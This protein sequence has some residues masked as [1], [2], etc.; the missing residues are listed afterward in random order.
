MRDRRSNFDITDSVQL[1]HAD[2]THRA[3]H[4]IF[5][6][7][8]KQYN[9]SALA[10][11]FD[12][13]ERLFEGDY[14][15]YLPCDT[16]YHDKQHTLD[17][18]LALARL[19]GGHERS[20]AKDKRIGAQRAVIAIITSLFHDSGYIRQEN[21]HNHFN[22]AEY[23]QTHVSRSAD[24]LKHYLYKIKLGEYAQLSARLV[25][26]SGYEIPLDTIQ[27]PDE[28]WRMSGY[29]LGTADVISQMADRC[30]LEKC[31]DRLYP[32]FVL[33]GLVVEIDSQGKEK[34]LYHSGEDLL[35]KTPDFFANDI[36]NR[37]NKVL[38]QTYLYEKAYFDGKSV[39]ID[40]LGRNQVFLQKLLDKND[41]SL[42][43]REAPENY[44]TRNFPGLK[45]YLNQHPF[46]QH[47][48][49]EENHV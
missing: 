42:I 31:R 23:S 45:N 43:K 47:S 4:E 7:L 28:Q 22:G 36:D 18:T 17:V 32:E 8:F 19:I 14:P 34:I 15:N 16:L 33:G 46:S 3:V 9:E 40:E 38:K 12:D 20:S 24:F 35:K 49:N 30:Y 25:H 13:F 1:T 27:L 10:Q 26:Y 41:F 6:N 39:Y 21:D 2:H 37:L 5:H 29:L 48:L 11:A 44:G